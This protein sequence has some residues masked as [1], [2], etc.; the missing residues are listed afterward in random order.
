MTLQIYPSLAAAPLTNL[1]ALISELE[2]AGVAAIHFD[3]EDGLFVPAMTLGTKLIADL[4]PLTQLPFDVHLMVAHPEQLLPAL[5]TI[6]ADRVAVHFEACAYPR[7]VLQSIAKSGAQAGIALNPRTP[8]PD[9][10]YLLPY[11]SFVVILSTEP[12]IGDSPLLPST[13]EKVRM[14][15][16]NAGLPSIEWVIDGGVNLDNIHDVACCGADAA[17]VGRAAFQGGSLLD[18]LAALRAASST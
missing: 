18:N 16:S 11:L 17:V 8:L 9:L 2:T 4:R 15:K 10:V 14:G 1:T 13:L 12:E 7:R 3:I 6:G 5:T